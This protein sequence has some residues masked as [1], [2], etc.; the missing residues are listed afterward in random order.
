MFKEKATF[1]KYQS[2]GSRNLGVLIISF[3]VEVFYNVRGNAKPKNGTR[4]CFIQH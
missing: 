1:N 2:N 3:R 4:K